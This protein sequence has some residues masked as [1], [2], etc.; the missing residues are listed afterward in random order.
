MDWD[1]PIPLAL[2]KEWRAWRKEL[3]LIAELPVPRRLYDQDLPVISAQLHGFSDASQQ[4]YGGVIYLRVVYQDTSISVK[5]VTSK[6]RVAPLPSSKTKGAPPLQNTIPRLELCGAHLLAKLLVA[7]AQDLS[8]DTEQIFAWTDSAI[9]LS[10]MNTPS[11][12]LKSYVSNRVTDAISMVPA[13][14]WHYVATLH[15]PAD[16]ASRGAL[17]QE[18]VNSVLWWSGPPWLCQPLDAWP[19]RPDI[20]MDRELPELKVQTLHLSMTTADFGDKFSSLT[21]WTRVTAWIRRFSHNARCGSVRRKGPL[22]ADELQE[23]FNQ[24]CVCTQRQFYHQEIQR[25]KGQQDLP[26]NSSLS[27]VCPYLDADGML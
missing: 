9:V 2:E 24:L 27:P 21:T 23:A 20:N 16:L 15:N 13:N 3:H 7:T 18:L 1:K 6:T 26:R 11:S 17:P 8:I 5:L 19:R 22:S 10:W 4:G 12:R 25:L 14:Q